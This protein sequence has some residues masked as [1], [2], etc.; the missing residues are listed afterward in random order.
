MACHLR[1]HSSS[2]LDCTGQRQKKKGNLKSSKKSA[3]DRARSGG[4]MTIRR[5]RYRRDYISLQTPSTE[6]MTIKNITLNKLY[7]VILNVLRLFSCDLIYYCSIKG[8]RVGRL[9]RLSFSI[10]RPTQFLEPMRCLDCV[11]MSVAMVHTGAMCAGLE[12]NVLFKKRV[13]VG[14]AASD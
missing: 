10:A 6:V 7:L 1:W 3:A 5:T 8:L 12:W 11:L 14:H 2:T 13:S 9:G 4:L